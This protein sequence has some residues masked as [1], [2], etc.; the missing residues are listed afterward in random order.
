MAAAY[1]QVLLQVTHGDPRCAGP[2]SI[3]RCSEP[4]ARDERAHSRGRN[5][6]RGTREHIP[7]FGTNRAGPESTFQGS[8]PIVR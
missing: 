5:Q 8:E 2:E 4:I 6:P 7:G 1:L 3:Y